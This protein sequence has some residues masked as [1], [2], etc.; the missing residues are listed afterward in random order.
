MGRVM[1]PFGVRGWVK[2]QTF[3]Q[4]AGNLK[5]YPLWQLGSDGQWRSFRVES[6]R[7]Q[8]DGLSAKLEAVEDRDAAMALRNCQIAVPRDSFPPA[9]AG[10]YYWT[11]LLG[12]SVVNTQGAHLGKVQRLME[13]GANDVMVVEGERERLLPFVAGVVKEVDLA[14]GVIRVDWGLDY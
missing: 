3:T 9:E 13:T 7:V 5:D 11:D 4:H 2:I 12:L 10:M 6:A 1:A 8:G 14:A